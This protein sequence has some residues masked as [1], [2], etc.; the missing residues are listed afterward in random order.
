MVEVC[1]TW[2]QADNRHWRGLCSNTFHP[3]EGNDSCRIICVNPKRERRPCTTVCSPPLM[4]P[5]SFVLNIRATLTLSSYPYPYSWD[6]TN[7][8]GQRTTVYTMYDKMPTAAQIA[9]P[10]EMRAMYVSP[11]GNHGC[12]WLGDMTTRRWYRQTIHPAAGIYYTCEIWDPPEYG[13]RTADPF[14]SC[15]P[16]VSGQEYPAY[17]CSS[18]LWGHQWY[19]AASGT[20]ATLEL[21]R[22]VAR[23]HSQTSDGITSEL[24]PLSGRGGG[25]SAIRT[26]TDAPTVWNVMQGRGS[27]SYPNTVPQPSSNVH[28]FNSYLPMAQ[29]RCLNICAN[30]SEWVFEKYYDLSESTITPGITNNGGPFPVILGLPKKLAV[31]VAI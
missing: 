10:I 14:D 29:W 19:M 23:H 22:D 21:R 24:L 16:E 6:H 30:R 20:T 8:F 11:S 7:P 3:T 5:I 27:F 1:K 31:S 17:V 15:R 26:E 13:Q 9:A 4:S 25:V 12:E 18:Q 28:F 2:K